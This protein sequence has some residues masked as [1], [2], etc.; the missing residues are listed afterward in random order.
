MKVDYTQV[1]LDENG[2]L[3][4]AI[5]VENDTTDTDT[6]NYIHLAATQP[7]DEGNVSYLET[8]SQVDVALLPGDIWE[9]TFN[10]STDASN[11]AMQ[12][13]EAMV[14]VEFAHA[15]PNGIAFALSD[16][17]DEE[18]ASDNFWKRAQLI[19]R[20]LII[21]GLCIVIFVLVRNYFPSH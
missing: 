2:H 11:K 17:Q 9:G 15:T 20:A 19:G 10:W 6:I 13:G 16:D 3:V 5:T 4:S 18:S 21:A 7:D 12:L 1:N 8:I 14:L